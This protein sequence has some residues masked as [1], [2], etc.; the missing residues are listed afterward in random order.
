MRTEKY[1]K[2]KLTGKAPQ[3]DRDGRGR[4]SRERATCIAHSEHQREAAWK[5]DEQGLHQKDAL[6]TSWELQTESRIGRD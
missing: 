4:T 5:G 6:L 2:I 3:E 1:K